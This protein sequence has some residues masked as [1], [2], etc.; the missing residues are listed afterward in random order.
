MLRF[1]AAWPQG[2]C[3]GSTWSRAE[4]RAKLARANVRNRDTSVR[5]GC[6]Q[7]RRDS[8]PDH[9]TSENKKAAGR[10]CGFET[11]RAGQ[12]VLPSKTPHRRPGSGDRS[13]RAN[14]FAAQAVAEEKVEREHL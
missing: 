1:S 5:Y 3:A 7:N 2:K 11:V 13:E 4:R 10:T 8:E 14:F 9:Q 6:D 12:H